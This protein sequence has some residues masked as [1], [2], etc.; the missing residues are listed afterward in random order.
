MTAAERVLDGWSVDVERR[1]LH[2][3][4][5]IAAAHRLVAEA[6]DADPTPPHGIVR[7]SG[8]MRP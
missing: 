3:A 6:F 7:P 2:H 5:V 1:A 4:A 8:V